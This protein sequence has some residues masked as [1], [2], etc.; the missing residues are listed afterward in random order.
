MDFQ[1]FVL[2]ASTGSMAEATDPVVQARAD[3]VEFRMDK[4]AT[5]LDALGRYDGRQPIIATNRPKWEG[6]EAP[7]S[8]RRLE[9]L[10]TAATFDAVEAIDVELE[11]IRRGQASELIKAVE[12]DV[13]VSV[14][15][16]DRTPGPED[17]RSLLNNA[18][19]HGDVGKLAV[20]AE[21][22]E[23]VPRLLAVTL[24][25]TA[26]DEQVATMAM[27]EPGQHSRAIAPIYGSCIGYAPAAPG[28]STAPGQYD[29]TTLANLIET[30]DPTL[31]N[32]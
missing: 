5:P 6:G 23:D 18:V 26:R 8:A 30:L 31:R 3:A 15:D 27:G 10:R 12:T 13:I 20:T 29:L 9:Q 17:L 19:E 28:K 11:S 24:E 4:A 1:S 25:F 32:Q 7:D 2:A 16:F 14:H 21:T 22:I